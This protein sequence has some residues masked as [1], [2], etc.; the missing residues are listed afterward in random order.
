MRDYLPPETWNDA[1]RR[2]WRV[3]ESYQ[4]NDKGRKGTDDLRRDVIAHAML[5]LV[6]RWAN[7]GDYKKP[8]H[9]LD[10]GPF[11]KIIWREC[12]RAVQR[13]IR[14]LCDGR[15]TKSD[16]QLQASLVSPDRVADKTADVSHIRRMTWSDGTLRAK[17]MLSV[18]PLD[19]RPLSAWTQAP[20]NETELTQAYERGRMVLNAI[21]IA[22]QSLGLG[23]ISD[24]DVPRACLVLSFVHPPLWH[25][26][27]AL[28]ECEL[29]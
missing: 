3:T 22:Y 1:R 11:P 27:Q 16:R 24:A 28:A 17:N 8:L 2:C 18:D 5:E 4:W 6:R 25:E 9:T 12:R 14:K 20:A 10:D 29:I 7:D 15:S 26:L 19:I 13:A 21:R 23:V